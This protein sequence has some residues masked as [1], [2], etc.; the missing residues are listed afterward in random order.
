MR[1]WACNATGYLT[2]YGAT[3]FVLLYTHADI[4][5][6][7]STSAETHP[8]L[9]IT[10]TRANHIGSVSFELVGAGHC[11]FCYSKGPKA[12]IYATGNIP[13]KFYTHGSALYV[14]LG[15]PNFVAI[16]SSARIKPLKVAA[17]PAGALP[18]LA[19]N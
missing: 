8:R 16:R 3:Q 15:T 18:V 14:D 11:S 7:V 17:L 12:V 2:A 9:N 13:F 6:S 19:L 1:H 10:A 4:N 5:N